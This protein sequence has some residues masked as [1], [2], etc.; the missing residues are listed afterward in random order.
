VLA[1]R[2]VLT[3]RATDAIS[4]HQTPSFATIATIAVSDLIEHVTDPVTVMQQAHRLL[5][6]NGILLIMT[7]NSRSLTNALMR[8]RWTHDKLEHM[9]YFN[10]RSIQELAQRSGYEVVSIEAAV[11]T[12]SPSYIR[13]QL[14]T[15]PLPLITPIFSALTTALGPL[16]IH[17]FPSSPT[18]SSPS[19]ANPPINSSEQPFRPRLCPAAL[20]NQPPNE[21][22]SH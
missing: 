12:L 8:R 1:P 17:G 6:P 16:A 4:H 15:Y 20:A 2:R 11:K 10:R 22:I 18:N 13:T 14:K 21:S 3:Q 9:L 5:Q 19:S 7:P